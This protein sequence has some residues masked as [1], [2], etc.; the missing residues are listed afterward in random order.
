MSSI[1]RSSGRGSAPDLPAGSSSPISGVDDTS[2]NASR[3]TQWSGGWT[4]QAL[5]W[6]PTVLEVVVR[7][8]RCSG[9][10][11]VWHQDTSAANSRSR[12]MSSKAPVARYLG[13]TL[14]R[15]LHPQLGRVCLMPVRCSRTAPHRCGAAARCGRP[16]G[17]G[18]VRCGWRGRQRGRTAHGCTGRGQLRYAG[19]RRLCWRR[20]PSPGRSRSRR[21]SR[22]LKRA[23]FA[24][25]AGSSNAWVDTQGRQLPHL[26]GVTYSVVPDVELLTLKT[27]VRCGGTILVGAHV[28]CGS[29][30]SPLEPMPSSRLRCRRRGCRSRCRRWT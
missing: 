11:H 10:G 6:R 2:A 16:T 8:Y 22:K 1:P 20:R 13:S 7:R 12:S 3:E 27:S 4:Q 18:T 9:C 5:S 14:Q 23:R 26:D 15:S 24:D 25:R 28:G 29:P 30:S 17:C 21:G 19:E